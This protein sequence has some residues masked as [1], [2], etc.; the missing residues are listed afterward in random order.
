MNINKIYKLLVIIATI[1]LILTLYSTC[2]ADNERITKDF[3]LNS[4]V[5]SNN[6][7]IYG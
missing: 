5:S 1:V 6:E 2:Y 4:Y 3:E 7:I